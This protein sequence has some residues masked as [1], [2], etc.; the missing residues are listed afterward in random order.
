MRVI[1]NMRDIF[2]MKYKRQGKVSP[3]RLMGPSRTRGRPKRT[4]ME[5]VRIDLRKCNLSEDLAQDRLEWQNI[6]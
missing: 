2:D 6:F 3:C 4:W 5:V 1:F